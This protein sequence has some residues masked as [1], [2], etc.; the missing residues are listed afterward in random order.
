MDQTLKWFE[1]YKFVVVIRTSS[2][3]DAEAMIKAAISGG[4]RIFEISMHT[5]QATRLI[6]TFPSA[7][8]LN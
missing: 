2:A 3:D 7:I 1:D 6:E 5:A 4:I 8:C